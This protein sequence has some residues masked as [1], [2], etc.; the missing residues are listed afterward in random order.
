MHVLGLSEYNFVVKL[1]HLYKLWFSI[2]CTPV[3][4]SFYATEVGSG[5]ACGAERIGSLN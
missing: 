3:V 1:G 2:R 4:K 5:A